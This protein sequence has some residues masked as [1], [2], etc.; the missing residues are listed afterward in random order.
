MG[1]GMKCPDCGSTNLA[2]DYTKSGV[3]LNGLH[4][5]HEITVTLFLGC[6]ECSATV[7]CI[8]LSDYL[9]QL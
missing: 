7:Q 1:K 4:R 2:W 8:P 9:G 5:I 6:N 3:V